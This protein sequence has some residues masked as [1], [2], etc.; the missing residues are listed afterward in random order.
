MKEYIET[1]QNETILKERI[2]KVRICLAE[3][4]RIDEES[5]TPS[6]TMF[7]NL[8]ELTEKDYSAQD[9]KLALAKISAE[10]REFSFQ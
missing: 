10:P 9:F 7:T 3:I 1:S 5:A 2:N 4:L 8:L 6:D